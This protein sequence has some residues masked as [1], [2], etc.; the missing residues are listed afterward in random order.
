M[1]KI[2]KFI[3]IITLFFTA[4]CGFKVL[5]KS[6]KNNFEIIEVNTNGNSRINYRIKSFLLENSQQN[7]GN[8]ISIE[9][10]T[11]II[12][13]VKEKNIKNEITK[14]EI[15]L[16]S[17]INT[18]LVN[19]NKKNNINLSVI[20][21]FSVDDNYSATISNEKNLTD[22]LAEEMAKN[23]LREVEKIINDI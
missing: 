3:L 8:I 21:D 4:S 9:V 7:S 10:K 15:N 13:S 6:N 17:N 16:V 20:G 23:I 14:Y 5:D 19:S 22:N 12:K 18:L 11:N 1:K 2:S